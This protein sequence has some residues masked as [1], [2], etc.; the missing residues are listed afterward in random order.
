MKEFRSSRMFKVIRVECVHYPDIGYLT[1]TI[2][3]ARNI[4]TP[5]NNQQKH[6]TGYLHLSIYLSF[7]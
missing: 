7:K 4:P 5:T 2:M 1:S 3:Y 6:A